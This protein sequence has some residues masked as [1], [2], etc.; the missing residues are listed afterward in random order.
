MYPR[1]DE[2]QMNRLQQEVQVLVD[3][4]RTPKAQDRMILR[5]DYWDLYGKM[6]QNDLLSGRWI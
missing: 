3:N 4:V 2:A 1:L 5:D 6:S